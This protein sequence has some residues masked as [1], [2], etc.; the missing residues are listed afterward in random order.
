[1]SKSC[2]PTG[3]AV[4]LVVGLGTMA[5]CPALAGVPGMDDNDVAA[6]SRAVRIALAKP[7]GAAPKVFGYTV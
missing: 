7:R 6:A 5:A 1:M 4:T 2:P 3:S